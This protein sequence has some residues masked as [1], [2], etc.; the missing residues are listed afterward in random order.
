MSLLTIRFFFAYEFFSCPFVPLLSRARLCAQN[1]CSLKRFNNHSP[2]ACVLIFS[3]FHFALPIRL[4]NRPDKGVI[5]ESDKRTPNW[6]FA[7]FYQLKQQHPILSTKVNRKWDANRFYVV[8]RLKLEQNPAQAHLKAVLGE[9]EFMCNKHDAVRGAL[10][11]WKFTRN[12]Q[13]QWNTPQRMC[14]DQQN[15]LLMR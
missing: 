7:L 9:L 5:N 2:F 10:M 12:G 6:L 14:A 15:S 4:K 1:F 13:R 11:A 8:T 3:K